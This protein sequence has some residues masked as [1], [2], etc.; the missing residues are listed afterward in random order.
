MYIPTEFGAEFH[1][2]E[3]LEDCSPVNL[4]NMD[5]SGKQSNQRHENIILWTVYLYETMML[6]KTLNTKATCCSYLIK[7]P[8][9]AFHLTRIRNC[10][11]LVANATKNFAL[12]T[13]ISQLVANGRL[14]ISCHDNYT[15][16]NFDFQPN[17]LK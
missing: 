13:R 15:N 17:R 14:T 12:A 16:N 9:E 4:L 2:N 10:A 1:W 5:W 7:R 6:T 8:W 3:K 11:F